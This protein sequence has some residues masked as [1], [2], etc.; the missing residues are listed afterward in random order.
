MFHYIHLPIFL[1]L[2]GSSPACTA[3]V[4]PVGRNDFALK[5]CS[6]RPAKSIALV[7]TLATVFALIALNGG[8][9]DRN[10]GLEVGH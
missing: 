6:L 5:P 2:S 4:A 3:V 9:S 8:F 7:R 10:K 1:I